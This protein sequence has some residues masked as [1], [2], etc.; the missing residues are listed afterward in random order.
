MCSRV[1]IVSLMIPRLTSLVVL[2]MFVRILEYRSVTSQMWGNISNVRDWCECSEAKPV[3]LH[4]WLMWSSNWADTATTIVPV[5]CP[6]SRIICA[7]AIA[8]ALS[9]RMISI[10][11]RWNRNRCWLC[12]SWRGLW[13]LRSW[14]LRGRS[15]RS[16]E[17][18]KIDVTLW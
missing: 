17:F 9:W 10:G 12:S 14:I 6:N 15:S 11:N 18:V 16:Y 5:S 2:R 7:S 8:S 4:D 3:A 13:L 1:M